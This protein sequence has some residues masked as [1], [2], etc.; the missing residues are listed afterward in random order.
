MA[1]HVQGCRFTVEESVE[2][3][4]KKYDAPETGCPRCPGGGSRK[5]QEQSAGF[6]L[7]GVVGGEGAWFHHKAAS[8]LNFFFLF[9][10]SIFSP[11][12]MMGP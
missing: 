5:L 6:Y 1:K 2:K 8:S 12:V 9:I 10:S 4:G 3:G 7:E 11:F